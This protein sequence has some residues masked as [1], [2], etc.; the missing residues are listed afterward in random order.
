M[1]G[2]CVQNVRIWNIIEIC[3]Q[4]IVKEKNY[5]EEIICDTRA[6]GI[7]YYARMINYALYRLGSS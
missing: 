3:L 1:E 2:N 5:N 7:L 6:N 4:L